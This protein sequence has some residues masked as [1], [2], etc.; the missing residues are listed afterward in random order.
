MR[1]AGDLI[2]EG[3]LSANRITPIG[4]GAYGLVYQ[5]DVPGNV[6]K[7]TVV[8]DEYGYMTNEANRQAIAGEMGI[9]PRV[10][11]LERFP[12]GV[13]NR[14][15]MQDIREN[16]EPLP[17]DPMLGTQMVSD[18]A[19]PGTRQDLRRFAVRQAQQMGELA[20]KGIEVDDRHQGNVMRHKMTGRPMQIDFG[21]SYDLTQDAAKAQVLADATADGFKAAGIPEMGSILRGIVFDH[22]EGGQGAEAL[23]V[24]KQG[25]SR[26]QKIKHPL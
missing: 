3:M 13:G 6:I 25:F 19:E 24:A 26:L 1:K 5:S 2:R 17:I 8:P 16:Y 9:A 23:D 22:L 15:E 12:G 7:Q 11:G 10:A 4:E 14:I 18:Y 21:I 20:L